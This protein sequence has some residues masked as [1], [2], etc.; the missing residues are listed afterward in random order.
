M[1]ELNGS[2]GVG[3]LPVGMLCAV[4]LNRQLPLRAG[5]IDHALADRVLTSKLPLRAK[6]P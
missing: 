5:E 4:E 3:S 1:R 6:G 2:R